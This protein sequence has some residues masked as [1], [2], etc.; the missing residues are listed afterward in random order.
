MVR[1]KAFETIRLL[2]PLIMGVILSLMLAVMTVSYLNEVRT[3]AEASITDLE[4][5]AKKYSDLSDERKIIIAEVLLEQ[6]V[7]GFKLFFETSKNLVKG[8][9]LII[10]L[11]LAVIIIQVI[12]ACSFLILKKKYINAIDRN[13]LWLVITMLVMG[14]LYGVYLIIRDRYWVSDLDTFWM[15]IFLSIVMAI[16]IWRI[17]NRSRVAALLLLGIAIF[18]IGLVIY[19]SIYSKVPIYTIH[20]Y[21]AFEAVLST[22]RLKKGEASYQSRMALTHHES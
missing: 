16:I 17:A 9:W 18:S 13:Q 15:Y 14:L 12:S 22:H 2:G 10:Y 19:L 3:V 11:L 4:T 21:L 5:T 1:V 20:L 7:G 6:D 8:Y